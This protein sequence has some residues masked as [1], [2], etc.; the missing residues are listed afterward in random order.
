MVQMMSGD[1]RAAVGVFSA[2]SGAAQR[3]EELWCQAVFDDLTSYGAPHLVLPVQTS[4]GCA[5]GRCSFCTYP[6]QEGDYRED[7]LERLEPMVRLAAATRADLSIKDAYLTPHRLDRVTDLVADRVRLAA[8]TRVAPGLD[9]SR[10]ERWVAG[11]LR[12]LELGVEALDP[13]VLRMVNKRQG[14]HHLLPAG[15][16]ILAGGA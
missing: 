10:I 6:G 14:V 7:G 13:R 12:T 2:G 16:S 9:R 1:P 5:Y 3:A 11:G 4:R 15:M 8:C